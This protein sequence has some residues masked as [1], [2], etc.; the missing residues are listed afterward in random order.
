M[1]KLGRSIPF[2][3][4]ASAGFVYS[5]SGAAQPGAATAQV[6]ARLT[7]D[8]KFAHYLVSPSGE[9]DGIVLEDGTVTRFPPHALALAPEIAP[10]QAGDVVRLEGDAVNGPTGPV[11]AHASVTRGNAVIVRGDLPPPPAPGDPGAGPRAHHG[12]KHGPRGAKGPHEESLRPLTVTGKIQG[13]STDPHGRVD[14]ILF[15]DGTNARAGKKVRLDTLALK[16]GD[17]ITV[18]GKGG[19]YP[20]GS[21]LHIETM[22]LPTGEVRSFD[23]SH[24]K[25]TP[26]SHEGE[27]A[28][29]L[30]NPRGDLDGFLLKDSTL[31]RVRPT[32]PIPQL[33]AGSRI[34][35]EGEG[36]AFFVRA[37]K[38]T[39][40]STG[41]VLDL[42]TPPRA[43]RVTPV[44]TMLDDSSIVVQVVNSP[45]GEI[46][47][48]VLQDGS[49][50]KLP[51]K[52]GD[53]AGDTI[54]VGTKLSVQGEGGTYGAVKAFRADRVQLA[55]GEIFSE[56]ERP[57][58]KRSPYGTTP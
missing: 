1:S 15:V 33:I 40:T 20:Q 22:K 8:G 35:A 47:T 42:S 31:I 26:V 29:I 11:L 32:A 2:L 16:A 24:A 45:E 9:V 49:I 44:L 4:L 36:T 28:C 57:S 30:L 17:T 54:R 51:R 10:L 46:D 34:R 43:V 52:L 27:I 6:P 37:D 21:S 23:F 38:V 14:G 25:L 7:I 18:T 50:V 3:V 53:E 56:P 12:G 48:L 58:P 39:L 19:N 41:A 5:S 13:F 55:S